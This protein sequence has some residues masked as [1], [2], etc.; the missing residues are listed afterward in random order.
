M[1]RGVITV[2]CLLIH[3]VMAFAEVTS[4][5]IT[6]R[7]I[8]AGGQSFGATGPYEKLVGRIEFALD[9]TDSHN[10]GIDERDRR[11]FDAMWIHIAGAARGSFNERFATPTHGD[12]YRPTK[13]PFSDVEQRDLD[14][15]RDGLESR[16]RVDQRPKIFY[17][18]TPVEYWGGGRA[19]ALTHTTLDG[20]RDL[21]LPEN[22]RIYLLAG[23]QH[24]EPAFP[25]TRSSPALLAR[26]PI[27]SP[28]EGNAA[29]RNNGQQLNN[30]VPQANVMRA[31]LRAWHQWA[32]SDIAPP[33]SQYPRLKN[34]TLVPISESRFPSIPGVSNPRR[35]V[36]PARVIG[37]KSRRSRTS[38]RRSIE[39]GTI[40]PASASRNLPCL[41]RRRPVGISALRPS[42]I[43]T[44]SISC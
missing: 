24:I 21:T 33:A 15:T 34:K 37:A 41:W 3:P 26:G 31:L 11:V 14:G 39:T 32:A 30:P 13:F 40:W 18:N 2:F 4:V 23:T 28:G 27:G 7:A 1:S 22:V 10:S 6:S 36:G 44:T 35:I 25:P 38:C 43:P 8:V 20:T 19:A 5:S 17:T 16:Y 9:P 42:G 29:A 12:A